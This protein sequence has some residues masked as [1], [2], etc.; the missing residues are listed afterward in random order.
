MTNSV[1]F[2]PSVGGDG[3]TVTDDSNPATGLA[4]GYH[5]IHFVPALSQTVA[6]AA[7]TVTQ[8]TNAAAS[9]VSAANSAAAAAVAVGTTSTS[10]TSNSVSIASKTFT[11]QAG[12]AYVIGMYVVVASTGTPANT[13]F[14]NITAYNSG[15]GSLTVNVIQITGSGTNT[16]WSISLSAPARQYP[17]PTGNAGKF[18]TTP[19]GVTETWVAIPSGITSAEAITTSTTLTVS[20]AG[21]QATAMTVMGQSVTLPDATTLSVG[22]PK[23][24]I[25]N[26]K[27]GY[28]I[29]IRDTSGTL[30]MGVA[31]G[32]EAIVS[33][34]DNSSASGIWSVTGTNMEPG[35]ITID[36]TFSSTYSLPSAGQNVFC[37]LDTNTSIHFVRLV[38]G[39]FA[40]FVVDNVG[41][42]VSTPVTVSSTSSIV[43][44]QCFKIS[45]T[46]AIVFYGV[47]AATHSAVVLT[48]TG[49]T[50]SY[51]LTIGTPQTDATAF[52][53][54]WG[55]E[56]FIGA[57][58]IAQ[59]TPTLYVAS[60][61]SATATSAFAIGVS[62]ATVTIGGLA[63][64][65]ASNMVALSTTTY[66][67]TSTTA[68]VLYKSGAAAPYANNAVVISVSGTTCTVNTPASLTGVTSDSTAAP[69]SCQ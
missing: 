31:A 19:D 16:D 63:T 66:A 25:D 20:S 38:A 9:A 13:M 32:G 26:T 67:L 60:A 44:V 49:T 52:S 27:G 17:N 1:T 7:N 11:T 61:V 51:S 64:I 3:S 34:R 39:G 45:T 65:T 40:A 2:S 46:S 54:P 23:Y 43:P 8:A 22:S 18:L 41:K 10:T 21:Y 30:L 15:T 68:L 37:T 28:P 55:G 14:G 6:V 69:M 48:L 5:R 56:N 57:P 42:V 33:L 62:G 35:L 53:S 50:P 36:S 24:I 58:K 59:L 29:G 47:G 12:K 4:G